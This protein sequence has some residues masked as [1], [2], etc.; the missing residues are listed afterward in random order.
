MCS[1]TLLY[2]A[3]RTAGSTNKYLRNSVE[4]YSKI[5]C[6]KV[7]VRISTKVLPKILPVRKYF[8]KYCT[9][10]LP[11][12]LSRKYGSILSKVRKYFESTRTTNEGT[13]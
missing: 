3:T 11:E 12:V 2:T 8:R 7:R 1:T 13:E 9:R 4:Y 10:V 5:E 6:T